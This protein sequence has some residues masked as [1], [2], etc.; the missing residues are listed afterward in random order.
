VLKGNHLVFMERFG[1]LDPI[2]A[3]HFH[4]GLIPLAAMTLMAL[5]NEVFSICKA[6]GDSFFH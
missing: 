3:P 2:F 5:M 1:T 4:K 6:P